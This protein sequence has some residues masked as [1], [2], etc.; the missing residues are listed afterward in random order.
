MSICSEILGCFKSNPEVLCKS[1]YENEL[2]FLSYL[3]KQP[4]KNEFIY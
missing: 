2:T 4:S 3:N 1:C